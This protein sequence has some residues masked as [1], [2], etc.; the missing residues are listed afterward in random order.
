MKLS[1][2]DIQQ[3]Q[4]RTALAGFDKR[5]V[6]T[7]LDLLANDFED[8][9]RE[10]KKLEEELKK[11]EGDLHEYRERERT[12]KETMLTATQIT[13]DIKQN[14]RKEAEIV[15]AQAEH[16]AEQIIQNAHTRLVRI[17]EDMDEL[18]RQKAQFEASLRSIIQAHDKL[19][20]AMAEREGTSGD[21]L[22]LRRRAPDRADTDPKVLTMR[23]QTVRTDE[24]LLTPRGG[25]R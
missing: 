7:F 15:I 19:L 5:E 18:R 4:F 24:D 11:R 22:I 25:D 8:L 6:D 16:Q 14:A 3:Q 23:D 2:L 17:M 10:N 9:V 20:D 12:L 13:E 1:P 21:T